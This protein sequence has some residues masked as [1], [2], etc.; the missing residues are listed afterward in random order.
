MIRF[1][2]KFQRN[3]TQLITSY[4]SDNTNPHLII[5]EII[6]INMKIHTVL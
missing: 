3:P 5:L 1:L 2:R 4:V 6:L